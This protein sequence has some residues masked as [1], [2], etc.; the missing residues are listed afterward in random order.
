MDIKT[1]IVFLT[2]GLLISIS[3]I[4]FDLF[5][6]ERRLW[7][8]FLGMFIGIAA[9]GALNTMTINNQKT[10][11]KKE[12]S[13]LA[14]TL[15][16]FIDDNNYYDRSQWA[17]ILG[18]SERDIA[19]W[20]DDRDIPQAVNIRSM[21]STLIGDTRFTD[22]ELE[23]F[24]RLIHRPSVDVSPHG[25]RMSPTIRHYMV[26]PVLDGF[27]GTLNTLSPHLQE[28]M[29]FKAGQMCR[30]ERENDHEAPSI[31]ELRYSEF[32]KHIDDLRARALSTKE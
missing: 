21:W 12:L 18:V 5:I 27:M 15:R 30:E 3:L 29:L 20:L 16:W 26:S 9:L 14:M 13:D 31:K 28:E 4:A 22:E 8:V 17:S 24:Y 2:G 10:I 32:E 1:S 7:Q 11:A 6:G 23:K 19:A 25:N